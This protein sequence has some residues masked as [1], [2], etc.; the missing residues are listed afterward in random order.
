LQGLQDAFILNEPGFQ[1]SFLKDLARISMKVDLTALRG[2]IE[3]EIG[4]VE[5]K[6]TR[7]QQQLQQIAAVEEI[8]R[9]AEGSLRAVETE[10]AT[11]EP[12]SSEGDISEQSKRWF[13]QG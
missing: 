8:A 9:N 1:V 2:L 12:I 4:R 11:E 10:E 3:E 13:Q 6:R 7:L 5:Q